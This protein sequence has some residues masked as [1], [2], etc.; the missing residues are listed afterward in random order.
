[1]SWFYHPMGH[2]WAPRWSKV[3]EPDPGGQSPLQASP[4]KIYWK[5]L[6]YFDMVLRTQG[7]FLYDIPLQICRISQ[8]F[9]CASAPYLKLFSKLTWLLQWV[10]TRCDYRVTYNKHTQLNNTLK[11]SWSLLTGSI[12][13]QALYSPSY[14]GHHI[15]TYYRQSK[16]SLW[17]KIS[18][19]YDLLTF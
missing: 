18:R 15:V 14:I 7:Y 17:G 11:L 6:N 5:I 4:G 8:I 13:D 1:M 2:I 10:G 19:I 16:R 3:V 12:T 9:V